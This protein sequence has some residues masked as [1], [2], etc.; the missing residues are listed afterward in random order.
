MKGVFDGV[1]GVKLFFWECTEMSC[2]K[3]G[4]GRRRGG[5]GWSNRYGKPARRCGECKNWITT[6]FAARRRGGRPGLAAARASQP[7]L[8]YAAPLV[9]VR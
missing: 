7:G 2:G 1:G 3:R 6:G 4:M 8:A 9:L 5:R